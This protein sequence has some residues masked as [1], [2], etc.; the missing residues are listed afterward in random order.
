[1]PFSFS[2]KLPF[3]SLLSVGS[4]AQFCTSQKPRTKYSLSSRLKFETHLQMIPEDE[5]PE[6]LNSTSDVKSTSPNSKRVS[7][8]KQ[9]FGS[10]ARRMGRKLIL[11]SIP[12]FPSLSSTGEQ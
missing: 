6:A 1:M 3:S 2:G 12:P 4:S 9:E 10:T 8:P 7:P 11:R 5:T